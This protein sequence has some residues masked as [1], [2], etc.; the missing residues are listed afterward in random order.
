MPKYQSKAEEDLTIARIGMLLKQPFFG[1]LAMKL[2]LVEVSETSK[3]SGFKTA[4][5]DGRRLWY[6]PEFIESLNK[7]ELMFLVA[8]EVLH[9]VF[10]HLVRRYDRDPKLWNMATDYV[11]NATLVEAGFKMPKIGL[12]EQKYL[13]WASEDVYDELK[14][15][16]AEGKETLDHHPGDPGYPSEGKGGQ[17]DQDGDKQ[18]GEG[19][20]PQGHGE[21]SE[22]DAKALQEEWRDAVVQAAQ[23]AAGNVPAGLKRLIEDFIDPKMDWRQLI[24][25][26][27]QSC[28]KT[29]YT[30]MRP[31]KRTFGSGIT[32]PSMDMDDHIKI[33]IAID[34]SGSVSEEMLKDFLSE[35]KG[36]MDAFSGYEIHIAC[37]DTAVHNPQTITGEDDLSEYE[38][39]GF[40]GTEFMAWWHFAEEQD[41]IGDVQK[42]L[43]FTDGYPWGDW[44]IPE[45][46]DTIFIVH[47][48]RNEAP[49]GTTVFYEDHLDN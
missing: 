14:S 12:Y 48:S 27:L 33:A 5:V 26:H 20:G 25:A 28:V 3:A 18:D 2:R 46:C 19:N 38:M 10:G 37:F 8:H 22:E 9:C 15:Q 21:M 30:W 47:G 7:D 35:V 32:M 13:N 24:Q 43:F 44:G 31:N 6:H 16:G 17:G 41:W 4:A 39:Q 34:T 1:T 42:I 49:F 40:G 36:I 23:A 29:D 45:L 11:I